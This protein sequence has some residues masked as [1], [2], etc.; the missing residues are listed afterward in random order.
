MDI[1][2]RRRTHAI[3]FFDD[4]DI[5][6][7]GKADYRR[8]CR[9]FIDHQLLLDSDKYQQRRPL[10]VPRVHLLDTLTG[11]ADGTPTKGVATGICQNRVVSDDR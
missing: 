1:A 10:W 4:M 8:R 2:R 5:F 6:V 9:R 3:E 11:K 7:C